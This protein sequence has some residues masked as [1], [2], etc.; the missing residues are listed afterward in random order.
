MRVCI[1]EGWMIFPW[2]NSRGVG[3]AVAG[4][5]PRFKK[6]LQLQKTWG[7]EM[8]LGLARNCQCAFFYEAEK[9]GP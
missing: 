2:G 5:T 1:Y 9:F 7:N 8:L 4:L 6:T 3:R